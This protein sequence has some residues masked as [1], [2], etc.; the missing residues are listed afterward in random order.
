MLLGKMADSR[1]G[2]ENIQNRPATFCCIEEQGI[3]QKPVGSCL[4]DSGANLNRLLVTNGGT[5][6]IL[7]RI[8]NVMD[9][10]IPNRFKIHVCFS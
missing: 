1:S 5:A 4:K 3:Y 2:E 9:C 6:G 10:N 7:I 8:I